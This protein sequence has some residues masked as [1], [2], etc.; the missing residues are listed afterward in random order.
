M[1]TNQAK[2][3]TPATFATAAVAKRALERVFDDVYDAGKGEIKKR[4]RRWKATRQIDTLY[5]QLKAVRMVKTIWQTEKAVDLSKFYYPTKVEMDGK[6]QVI[7][8]LSDLGDIGNPV[9]EG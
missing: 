7:N 3:M 2:P 4:F 5:K 1:S 9:V 8:D 6:R